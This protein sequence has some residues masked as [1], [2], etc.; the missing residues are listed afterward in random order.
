MLYSAA[1]MRQ[2]R[3]FQRGVSPS[4]TA[5]SKTLLSHASETQT[6]AAACEG[7]IVLVAF[8]GLAL[9]GMAVLISVNPTG[10]ASTTSPCFSL[11]N[12][13]SV[14]PNPN[15][16]NTN[17]FQGTGNTVNTPM[18]CNNT[19]VV[20]PA[21]PL[22]AVGST[23]VRGQALDL[24]S[25]RSLFAPGQI[26]T[27]ATVGGRDAA[28]L[29]PGT[30]ALTV[31]TPSP[32]TSW[33][34]CLWFYVLG[35]PGT[36][37][38]AVLLGTTY[39]YTNS[40]ALCLGTNP[41]GQIYMGRGNIAGACICPMGSCTAVAVF[42]APGFKAGLINGYPQAAGNQG[43]WTH[44]CFVY[45]SQVASIYVNGT[46][47]TTTSVNFDTATPG[48]LLSVGAPTDGTSQM[49]AAVTC[50]AAW[51]VALNANQVVSLY[52]NQVAP[53]MCPTLTSFSSFSCLAATTS[54]YVPVFLTGATHIA[55]LPTVHL[56][57]R[58]SSSLG[59][60]FYISASQGNDAN[61]GLTVD[62]PWAT[63]G[64]INAFHGGYTFAQTVLPGDSYLFCNGDW[65][66]NTQIS[67]G[68]SNNSFG[69]P[70]KPITIGNYSCSTNPGTWSTPPFLS[71]GSILPQATSNVGWWRDTSW[72]F[73]NGSTSGNNVWAYRIGALG[74][75]PGQKFIPGNTV[76][77][78]FWLDGVNYRYA[79]HPNYLDP[80]V[81]TGVAMQEFLWYDTFYNSALRDTNAHNYF[82]ISGGSYCSSLFHDLYSGNISAWTKGAGGTTNYYSGVNVQARLYD[83]SWIYNV[84]NVILQ[85]IPA[86]YSCAQ[87]IQQYITGPGYTFDVTD[88]WAWSIP[89]AQNSTSSFYSAPAWQPARMTPNFYALSGGQG[90]PTWTDELGNLRGWGQ[91][92][93]LTGHPEFLDTPGEWWF[94]SKTKTL[95]VIPLPGHG[96]ILAN[97]YT[98]AFTPEASASD[99]YFGRL[100]VA[101]MGSTTSTVISV[102][103]TNTNVTLAYPNSGWFV[104][105]DIEVAYSGYAIG[106][107]VNGAEIYNVYGH[108]LT[109]GG[110]TLSIYNTTAPGAN[111][112]YNSVFNDVPM[113]VVI[114]SGP[115]AGSQVLNVT[116][117]NLGL[118]FGVYSA[119]ISIP[120]GGPSRVR[121]CTV[122]NVGGNANGNNGIFLS[123]P[124]SI[125]EF[126]K[127]SNTSLMFLDQ[128]AAFASGQWIYNEVVNAT[129]NTIFSDIGPVG[130]TNADLVYASS[131]VNSGTWAMNYFAEAQG[132]CMFVGAWQTN[133]FSNNL[134]IDTSGND[135]DLGGAS[136]Y[137]FSQGVGSVASF[138]NNWAMWTEA[139][140][141][142][143]V[144]PYQSPY[145]PQ[146]T[147]G[148]AVPSYI[149]NQTLAYTGLEWSNGGVVNYPLY[150]RTLYCNGLLEGSPGGAFKL[151]QQIINAFG[152]DADILT[153]L[154]NRQWITEQAFF[155]TTDQWPGGVQYGQTYCQNLAA[156]ALADLRSNAS[157]ARAAT[158]QSAWSAALGLL[159]WY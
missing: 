91:G 88:P 147:V 28:R 57:T 139:L 106:M 58:L 34:Y 15:D 85:W 51:S 47:R 44:V 36:Y 144:V 146:H 52:Q 104:V 12:A 94:D 43:Y 148:F 39:S 92:M 153:A 110:I 7:F 82:S 63:P 156:N 71:S 25:G 10:S 98:R 27:F 131:G 26:V 20:A 99:A 123:S 143:T 76:P 55:P 126:N 60:T 75:I 114:S 125:A 97:N 66:F 133:T 137:L 67:F 41:A 14:C 16:T 46:L 108:N 32:S 116:C 140:Y 135:N 77:V 105:H 149:R 152:N 11:G 141:S 64:P 158:E 56:P 93:Q 95:Y 79:T 42:N 118:Q 49:S 2:K 120:H 22:W 50:V 127:I 37:L 111:V 145:L 68:Y 40:S 3:F 74:A 113:C 107:T 136:N 6:R 38:P 115:A 23:L 87:W 89:F 18:V 31:K 122:A 134:C 72:V 130:V 121:G 35:F 33:S 124:A 21:T 80:A 128:G 84:V 78:A 81:R 117:T 73:A 9:A 119:G 112:I 24:V 53:H 129:S 8:L 138:S 19:I 159:Q 90:G 54:K 100:A 103:T 83:A 59:R 96:A 13:G 102:Q 65:W 109:A 69:T 142:S 132:L 157:V 48:G 5:A 62:T 70:S 86:Q 101:L 155:A 150:L 61:D 30:I 17:S 151:S 4:H 1:E 154:M 29:D 45:G